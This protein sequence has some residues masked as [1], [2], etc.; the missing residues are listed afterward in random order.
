MNLSSFLLL[1]MIAWTRLTKEFWELEFCVHMQLL[2][3]EKNAISRTSLPLSKEMKRHTSGTWCIILCRRVLNWLGKI[4]KQQDKTKK[5]KQRDKTNIKWTKTRKQQTK[6][7]NR[8]NTKQNKEEITYGPI[9][10][11]VGHNIFRLPILRYRNKQKFLDVHCRR[12]YCRKI[13]YVGQSKYLS[14]QPW[15]VNV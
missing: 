1:I 4:N 3:V 2:L 11:V 6:Q 12:P 5:K 14:L 15:G 8:N 7:K 13:A 9:Q 10:P